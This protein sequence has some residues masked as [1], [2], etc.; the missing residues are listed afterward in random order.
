[1][2]DLTE[3]ELMERIATGMVQNKPI[4]NNLLGHNRHW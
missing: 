4:D 3:V 2:L 1:M